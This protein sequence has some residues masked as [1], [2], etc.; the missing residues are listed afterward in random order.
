[1][2][3][4]IGEAT[5]EQLAEWKKKHGVGK[6]FESDGHVCYLRYPTRTEVSFVNTITDGIKS[7]AKLL[8]T[9]W[10]GGSEEFKTNDRFFF[11]IAAELKKM[12]TTKEVQVE[13][14]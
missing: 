10:L 1:M 3:K 11:A 9:I 14:F 2:P 4:I 6:R 12:I 13:D 7:N 5:P 8:E